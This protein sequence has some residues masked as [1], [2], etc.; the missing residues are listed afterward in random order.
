MAQ[1]TA[2][3]K[4]QELVDKFREYSH[5]DFNYT[6]GG[7]QVDTQIQNAKMC[8]LIAVDE[9]YR[10]A[11]WSL[12]NDIQDDSKQYWYEVKQEIEKL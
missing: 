7:Y 12:E 5:T 4:A 10:I 6:R 1:Q 2:K 9:L 11:P 8:A 3:E